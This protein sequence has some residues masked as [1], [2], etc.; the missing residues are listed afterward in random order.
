MG[1][2]KKVITKLVY[3][4]KTQAQWGKRKQRN[5]KPQTTNSGPGIAKASETWGIALS[6]PLLAPDDWESAVS[7]AWCHMFKEEKSCSNWV[8]SNRV[9]KSDCVAVGIKRTIKDGNSLN[10]IW[11]NQIMKVMGQEL[12]SQQKDTI[13]GT[14]K[15]CIRGGR[16]G[17]HFLA[18]SRANTCN[19][20]NLTTIVLMALCRKM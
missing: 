19:Y 2:F 4:S 8:W 18:D 17:V 10:F 14:Q 20:T 3:G 5:A 11:K 12:W 16:Y 13:T 6:H 15:S 7:L 1:T 9:C